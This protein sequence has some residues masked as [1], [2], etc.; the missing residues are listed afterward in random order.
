MSEYVV[1]REGM[2]LDLCCWLHYYSADIGAVYELPAGVVEAALEAN[3]RIAW[4]PMHL[5]LGTKITMP[6]LPSEPVNKLVRLWD[7]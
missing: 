1:S 7:V 4:L 3:P 5:P 6:S 2:T